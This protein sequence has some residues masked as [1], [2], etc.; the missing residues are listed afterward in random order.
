MRMRDADPGQADSLTEL[1]VRSLGHWGHP[2][3]F[4]DLVQQVATEDRVTPEYI[5]HNVVRVLVDDGTT[6][7]FYGLEHHD[8][9]DE[10]K[11]MF[12]E[13]GY[14][15]SGNGRALWD[16]V[17]ARVEPSRRLRIVSDPMAKDFYAAMGAR[18][19]RDIEVAPGFVLGLM[20][21]E[22]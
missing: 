7:G 16:D 18:L 5:E 20:W 9:Y 6:V 3:N 21:F 15:G 13:P 2:D 10:L 8:E 14:I 4:P 1:L 17:I 12:L 22:R 11:Y 19:E